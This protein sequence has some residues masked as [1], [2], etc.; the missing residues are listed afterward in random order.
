MHTNG[1][2]Q[3][4]GGAAV[5]CGSANFSYSCEWLIKTSQRNKC[6]IDLVCGP[7][8]DEWVLQE[9]IRVV[10]NTELKEP[11]QVDHTGP[12]Q[13]SLCTLHTSQ[14]DQQE[15]SVP[16]HP[17]DLGSAR[18]HAATLFDKRA[19]RQSPKKNRGGTAVFPDVVC[20]HLW[21]N[22]SLC[23]HE[24]GTHPTPHSYNTHAHTHTHNNNAT[25]GH[26]FCWCG[27]I[28][29]RV[30]CIFVKVWRFTAALR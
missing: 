28:T 10:N 30:S 8:D 23:E 24:E 9:P 20:P 16:R 22:T 19:P 1:S 27:E 21:K 18:P 29:K 25:D 17:S 6:K 3:I 13:S 26:F 14:G 15:R 2:L 7:E 11:D 12:S 4:G 5:T